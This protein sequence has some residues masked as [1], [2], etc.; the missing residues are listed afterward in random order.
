MRK[1]VPITFRL[2]AAFAAGFGL[3]IALLLLLGMVLSTQ[4]CWSCGG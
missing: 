2:A 3:L 4:I 1:P